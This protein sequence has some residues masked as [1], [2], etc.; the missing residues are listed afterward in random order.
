MPNSHATTSYVAE[1]T[2]PILTFDWRPKYIWSDKEWSENLYANTWGT[3]ELHI[4]C[5]GVSESNCQCILLNRFA[6]QAIL[7]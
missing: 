1:V 5:T 4:Y 2:N 3:K 6:L 7:R